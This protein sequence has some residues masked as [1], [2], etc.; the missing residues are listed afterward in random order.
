MTLL[1][2]PG[3]IEELAGALE[4]LTGALP[5]LRPP[6]R[7]ALAALR[8]GAGD[9]EAAVALERA[10]VAAGAGARDRVLWLMREQLG[11]A[12]AAE[13]AEG[14]AELLARTRLLLAPSGL[15]RGGGAPALWPHAAAQVAL[16]TGLPCVATKEA[17]GWVQQA[18]PRAL[19][20]LAPS[21]PAG[22][23]SAVRAALRAL[24]SPLQGEAGWARARARARAAVTPPPP[25]PAPPGWSRRR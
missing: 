12:G 19:F 9:G 23:A 15:G 4:F 14:W 16:Q 21:E 25:P 10:W 24:D 18:A 13:G 1:I 22:F 17:L 8:G 20:R 11:G 2:D 7:L 5:R 3:Q 6:L